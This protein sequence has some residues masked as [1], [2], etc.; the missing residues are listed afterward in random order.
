MV[1]YIASQTYERF[2]DSQVISISFSIKNI[3]AL[4]SLDYL[5]CL[6]KTSLYLGG[7]V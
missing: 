7:V 1:V 2:I 6:R 3:E 4:R 5:G